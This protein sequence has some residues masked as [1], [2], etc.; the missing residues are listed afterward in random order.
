M[1]DYR[2][3]KHAEKDLN[4]IPAYTIQNFGLGQARRYRDGL[5]KTLEMITAF[6]L[7]GSDQSQINKSKRMFGVMPTNSMRSTAGLMGKESLFY[8]SWV[9][10]KALCG[11]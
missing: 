4:A 3:S 10:A 5:F 11:I 7:I 8:A 2:L 6:P 1:A 9:P